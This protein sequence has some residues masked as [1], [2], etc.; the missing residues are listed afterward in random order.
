MQDQTPLRSLVSSEAR[1]LLLQW[2]VEEGEPTTVGDLARRFGLTPA[3]LRREVR[4]LEALEVV[5]VVRSGNS[6][7]VARVP[8]SPVWKACAHLVKALDQELDRRA[9]TIERVRRDMV[10]LGA[11]LAGRPG[12]ARRQ[13]EDV[14]VEALEV[15]H[16][17][18]TVLRV[19]PVVLLAHADTLDWPRLF[20]TART[21][22]RAA[23]LGMLVQL[24]GHLANRP[25][26]EARA[27]E[28][29]DER[30]RAVRPFHDRMSR[31]E[32]ALAHTRTPDVVRRWGYLVNMDEA[33]FRSTLE[34]HAAV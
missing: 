7:V 2:A 16:D 15:A 26:L 18:A 31:R 3:G 27:E 17:D 29:K 5:G 30:R 19:L 8:S 33:S 10:A 32:L 14:L 20:A 12:K 23:E 6:D 1:A 4:T 11:P 22:R 28:L 9:D 21:E 13:V 25:D 34:R 24:T